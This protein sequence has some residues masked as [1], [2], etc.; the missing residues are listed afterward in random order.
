M[1]RILTITT[2]EL[3]AVGATQLLMLF[4]AAW[5][6]GGFTGDDFAH[7]MGG[8]HYIAESDGRIVAH[9]ALIER[10]LEA[11]TKPLRTGYV[12]GVAT[13]PEW[14]G[15]GLATRLMTDLSSYI[16]ENFELGAL[17]ASDPRLYARLGWLPWEGQLAIRTPTGLVPS[18]PAEENIMILRTVLTPRLPMRPTLTCDR[19]RGDSW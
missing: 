9:A 8:R 10:R 7:A 15:R 3:G 18:D 19:R 16:R 17:S 13:L 11:D 2:D 12:E 14:Q 1:F 5:P 4:M 6:D